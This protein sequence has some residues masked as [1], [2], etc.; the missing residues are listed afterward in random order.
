MTVLMFLVGILCAV[1]GMLCLAA[2][3]RPLLVLSE[4]DE[5]V[6]CCVLRSGAWFYVF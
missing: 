2:L 6:I 3:K 5:K 4:S 1:A